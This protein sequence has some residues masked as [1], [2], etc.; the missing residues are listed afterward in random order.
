MWS[1]SFERGK[2]QPEKLPYIKE[3]GAY[4]E[5]WAVPLAFDVLPV[6]MVGK[7]LGCANNFF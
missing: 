6:S 5:R 7:I 3:L 4:C 1:R 2:A